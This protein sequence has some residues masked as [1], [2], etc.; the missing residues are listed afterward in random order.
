[1]GQMGRI[2]ERGSYNDNG[3]IQTSILFL[4]F[5]P[6]SRNMLFQ[7]QSMTLNSSAKIVKLKKG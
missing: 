4:L 2:D 3:R 6:C 1:M 5:I 7:T